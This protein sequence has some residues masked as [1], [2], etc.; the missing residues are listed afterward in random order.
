MQRAAVLLLA[1]VL[2]LTLGGAALAA[3]TG[4]DPFG[5]ATVGPKAGQKVLLAS[6]QWLNPAGTRAVINNGGKMV[7]STVSPDGRKL[8]ALTWNYFTGFLSIID[9]KT[10]HIIQT[11]GTYPSY[12]GDGSVAADGPMYSP[13]G[14]TL[15]LGQATDLVR[16]TVKSDGTVTNPIVIKLPT[17]GPG[18]GALP[19]GM[20]LSS[21]GSKLYVALNGYNTLGVIDTATNALVNQIQVGIAPPSGRHRR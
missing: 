8:A 4:A 10:G 12:L 9:L 19:S 17:T 20:A 1:A 3:G 15:W 14:K 6:N 7:S 18:G 13:N 11:V 5:T 2:S 21:N 16:F